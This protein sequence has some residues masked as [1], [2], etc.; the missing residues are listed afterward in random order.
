MAIAVMRAV[1][2]VV[3]LSIVVVL[4]RRPAVAEMAVAAAELLTSAPVVTGQRH[5]VEPEPL[6]EV[7]GLAAAAAPSVPSI[8]VTA[9]LPGSL[10]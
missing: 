1:L 7:T 3:R 9:A 10:K 2:A 6:A 5:V 4:A 8:V